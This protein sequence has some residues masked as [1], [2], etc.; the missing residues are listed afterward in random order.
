[1]IRDNYSPYS[2]QAFIIINY[3]D[4][5]C[6]KARIVIDYR[7]LIQAAKDDGYKIHTTSDLID[8]VSIWQSI[9]FS[10]FDLKWIL[11]Y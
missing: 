4:K 5:I 9:I 2:R 3:F 10:M 6:G 11:A 1:M 8:R 7:Q